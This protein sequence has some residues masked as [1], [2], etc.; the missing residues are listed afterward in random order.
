M[1]SSDESDLANSQEAVL[2]VRL[3]LDQ[4]A[5]LRRGDVWDANADRQG[6]F[7]TVNELARLMESWLDRQQ[8]NATP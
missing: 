2:I 3:V 7:E 8:R 6:R 4:Q 1:N 5:H